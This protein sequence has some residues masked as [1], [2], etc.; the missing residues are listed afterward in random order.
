MA[1]FPVGDV[2]AMGLENAMFSGRD[3]MAMGLEKV[4]EKRDGCRP[5]KRDVP[6]ETLDGQGPRTAMDGCRSTKGDILQRET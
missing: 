3:V 5:R 2:M 4:S 6:H 1:M